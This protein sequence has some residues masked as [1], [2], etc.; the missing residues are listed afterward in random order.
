MINHLSIRLP[1]HD[2]GWD[3]HVCDNPKDNTFC[4]GARSCAGEMIR[5][6]KDLSTEEKHAGRFVGEIKGYIPPCSQQLNTFSKRAI[7]H[8][9]LPPDWLVK[10][11]SPTFDTVTPST[12]GTWPYMEVAVEE[13]IGEGSWL[14]FADRER[15][16]DEFF[17]RFTPKESLVFFY[18]NHDNPLI[19]EAKQFLL[20]GCATLSSIGD[21][22]RWEGMSEESIKNPKIGNQV[23]NRWI[24]HTGV[25]SSATFPLHQLWKLQKA[26]RISQKECERLLPTAPPTL[27]E[28]FRYVCRS[29][30]AGQALTLLEIL[31][32]S[33]QRGKAS[34]LLP[35]CNWDANIDWCNAALDKCWHDRGAYPGLGPILEWLGHSQGS[36]YYRQELRPLED[37][38]EDPLEIVKAYL[39]D[40]TKA[41]AAQQS[42]FK[43]A[44]T[45]W[46]GVS[47]P[48]VRDL[49][50]RVLVR[51]EISKDQLTTVLASDAKERE[52]F[53]L[54]SSIEMVAQ[55][56]YC[57]AEEMTT[58][59][60]EMPFEFIDQGVCPGSRSGH[61]RLVEPQDDGRIRALAVAHLRKE[62]QSG[63]TWVPEAELRTALAEKSTQDTP[64][65]PDE[66]LFQGYKDAWS[67]KIGF[68]AV[69]GESRAF[70][71]SIREDEQ[72]VEKVIKERLEKKISSKAPTD[73]AWKK[74]LKVDDSKLPAE[75]ESQVLTTQ[76]D[77]C[78]VIFAAGLGVINGS[79]GT[80]KTSTLRAILNEIADA[81]K[82]QPVLLAFTGRAA[83][84]LEKRTGLPAR[85]I[86]SFLH[87][88]AW[89]WPKTWVR[90]GSGGKR[91]IVTNLII[92]EASM[93]DIELLAQLFRAIDWKAVKRLILVGDVFQLPPIGAGRPFV[94]ILKATSTW[95]HQKK[96]RHIATL[97]INIRNIV[98]GSDSIQLA[99]VF[100]DATI[101]EM[102]EILA[103][104]RANNLPHGDLAVRE[105]QTH[106]ELKELLIT[107]VA[108]EM[109]SAGLPVKDEQPYLAFNSWLNLIGDPALDRFQIL[110]PLRKVEG[111]GI[112][113]INLWL[114]TWLRGSFMSSEG[115]GIKKIGPF[116]QWDKILI[117][118]N[119]DLF[120]GW[121]HNKKQKFTVHVTNGQ[122][123]AICTLEKYGS[124][125]QIRVKLPEHPGCSVT[126]PAGTAMDLCELAY[127]TTVHK[128]QGS[129]FETL[130]VILPLNMNWGISRE[131]IYTALT[132]AKRRVVLF[133]QGGVDALR[134]AA[135][136]DNSEI[137]ARRSTLLSNWPRGR[138][139]WDFDLQHTTDAG[140]KVISK[141]ECLIAN[142]LHEKVPFDYNRKLV[143]KTGGHP[144]YPDFTLFLEDGEHYWEHAGMLSDPTYYDRF[145]KKQAWYRKEG[146][147]DRLLVSH[148]LDGVDMPQINKVIGLLAK[149]DFKSA[150]RI[151]DPDVQRKA[152]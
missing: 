105:F 147:V 142:A 136:A 8:E 134:T 129:E 84:I 12:T 86:H 52:P 65:S 57:L 143:S 144:R 23:W 19:P 69:N 125:K 103:D 128:A 61:P 37:K 95:E 75:K 132:R 63:H 87:E 149:G 133:L 77:A 18:L 59:G 111:V 34:G 72:L 68:E 10:L 138:T 94:D 51:L 148:E 66:Y 107:E 85:T 127:A 30:S 113:D 109:R 17:K 116:T 83:Q 58:E 135:L 102:N 47:N 9:H 100:R 120:S 21:Q 106:E 44:A 26:G 80:G 114:Q 39:A 151:F 74:R 28:C 42:K 98:E 145:K 36:L 5:K 67:P 4:T 117:R 43:L 104:V 27:N 64:F 82:S 139:H 78:K 92:D 137:M 14:P 49:I 101:G 62:A 112:D 35:Q 32:N 152:P 115:Y 108:A 29:F 88:T 119:R 16:I 76:A 79:A 126:I 25:E 110:A 60:R 54:T 22:N 81:E 1:W 50:L 3:G 124:T 15:N 38:G 130:F 46:R 150:Q 48:T 91:Q 118:K 55:N 97:K 99:S 122:L 146:L 41:P 70:L 73:A 45:K 121:D 33:L 141:S 7:P 2:R 20:V 71:K 131:L 40:P 24:H 6:Y 90:K 56:P 31:V 53:G 89:L 93:L 123:G 140:F 96:K 11:R 13:N